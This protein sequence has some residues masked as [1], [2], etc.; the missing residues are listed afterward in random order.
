[1]IQG[2]NPSHGIYSY[3]RL[4]GTCHKFYWDVLKEELLIPSHSLT[5]N[6]T[7]ENPDSSIGVNEKVLS[8]S[9]RIRC[10]FSDISYLSS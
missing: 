3:K 1:M 8:A 7:I 2:L 10:I 6:Q 5:A 4:L 9:I